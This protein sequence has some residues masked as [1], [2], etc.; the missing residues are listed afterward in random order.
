MKQHKET[1][2]PE[3]LLSIR[4]KCTCAVSFVVCDHFQRQKLKRER[5]YLYSGGEQK[6]NKRRQEMAKGRD[7]Y[8]Q[9]VAEARN[10]VLQTWLRSITR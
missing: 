1:F 4:R 2:T 9:Y 5:K 8:L 7:C 6:L 10:N 3:R